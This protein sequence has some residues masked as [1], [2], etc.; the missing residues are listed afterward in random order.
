[1]ALKMGRTLQSQNPNSP[2]WHRA[3][4]KRQNI[5]S[6]GEWAKYGPFGMPMALRGL[7]KAFDPDSNWKK[8]LGYMS[9]GL[10]TGFS[11]L[12]GR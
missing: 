11:Q 10:G 7:T 12:F 6:A 8:Y 4:E 3:N 2:A 9:G 1:M 5:G